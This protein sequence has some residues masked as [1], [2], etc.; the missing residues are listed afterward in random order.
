M[1]SFK[2]DVREKFKDFAKTIKLF[3]ENQSYKLFIHV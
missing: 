2:N 1:E 3:Y